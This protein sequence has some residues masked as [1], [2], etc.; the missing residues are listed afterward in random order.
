MLDAAPG[1]KA[2]VDKYFKRFER[3]GWNRFTAFDWSEFDAS[4]LTD[5]Q[6]GAVRT[7]QLIEDHIPSY[8]AEYFRIF[9]LDPSLPADILEYRRQLLRFVSRWTAD[10]DRHAHTLE[11]YLRK[12][13]RVDVDDLEREMA[14]TVVRPY[15]APAEHSLPLA[16]YT[17]VQEKAT[18]L[19]Y[20]CLGQATEEPVLKA[21]M[22]ELNADE[23]RHCGFFVDLLRLHLDSADAA[24]LR[25]IKETVDAFGMP[26]A[27]IVTNYRRRSIKMMRAAPGYDFRSAFEILERA[28][29]GYAKARSDSRSQTLDDLLKTVEA[30]RPPGQRPAAPERQPVAA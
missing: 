30:I 18:Q 24:D 3:S 1:L 25:A 6:V 10:E 13:G 26:L 9:P 23:A 15:T 7:A 2:V 27:D 29:A 21:V 17:S 11:I 16:V 22:S 4:K 19:F 28:L 20:G 12:C 14:E 8:T 5:L